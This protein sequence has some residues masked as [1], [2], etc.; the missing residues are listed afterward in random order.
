[1]PAKRAPVKLP[2]PTDSTLVLEMELVDRPIGA[3]SA[4][5]LTKEVETLLDTLESGKAVKLKL[6]D[7]V[8]LHKIHMALRHAVA[9]KHGLRF[10]YRKIGEHTML[11]W[12]EKPLAR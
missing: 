12:A 2:A 4:W 5:P 1:M 9:R 8:D 3:R 7:Q 6:D 10:R 11:A